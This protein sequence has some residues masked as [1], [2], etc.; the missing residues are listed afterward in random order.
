VDSGFASDRALKYQNAH[1]LVAK[2]LTLWRIMRRACDAS[3]P[4]MIA[5]G[6]F[7]SHSHLRF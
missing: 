3:S 2:P 6:A 7:T 4:R 1:D 5:V